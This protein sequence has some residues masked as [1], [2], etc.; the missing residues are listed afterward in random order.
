MTL[1]FHTTKSVEAWCKKFILKGMQRFDR[2]ELTIHLPDGSTKVFGNPFSGVR[3]SMLIS[4]ERLFYRLVRDGSIG[5]GESYMAGE[6]ETDNLSGLLALLLN[7]SHIIDEERVNI[8]R[9]FR[10]IHRLWHSLKS[11]SLRGSRRNIRA[12]YDLGNDLFKLFLDPT[13]TYS[14][15]KFDDGYES[16]KLAQLKKLD[17]II[18]KAR[19]TARDRVLEIGS[20]WGSFAVRAAKTTGCHV[21]SLTLSHEQKR[22]VQELI[23]RENLTDRVEV[24]LCD[25]RKMQGK[26]DKIISIEML[27]AVGHEHL[28][29]FFKACEHLLKPDGLVVIQGI[30]FPDG[31]YKNYLKRA[32]WIQKYIFPGSH[33]PSLGAIVEANEGR[34]KL[35]LENVENIS[36]HYARTLATWLKTFRSKRQDILKL[37][38]DERFIKMWEFY[39]ASCQ[40]EFETRWLSLL[41]MVFT[42]PNN[43][44]L[45]KEDSALPQY[46][47]ALGRALLRQV[48]N[49]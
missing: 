45:I 30:I 5:L 39:L 26:F 13:L 25:Y 34:T 44:Q 23:K 46:N 28:T 21:T 18:S 31:Y 9:P 42:R 6:W 19:I 33:L 20:G 8:F 49:E 27:E 4:N 14:S 24:K 29:A 47:Q 1:S 40:A 37:G 2:G 16:L 35:Q 17:S 32:D 10:F 38:Y 43:Q 41:Q 3:Q 11:N 48:G 12:H 36:P 15:A 7:N 22:Y